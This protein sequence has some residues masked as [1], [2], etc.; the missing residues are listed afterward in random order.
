MVMQDPLHILDT[1]LAVSFVGSFGMLP[2]RDLAISL[3]FYVVIILKNE[4]QP[5]LLKSLSL[6]TQTCAVPQAAQD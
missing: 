4:P 5:F 1:P 2:P 3:R 6:F